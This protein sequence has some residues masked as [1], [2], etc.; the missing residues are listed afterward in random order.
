M[1]NR[2]RSPSRLTPAVSPT[3]TRPTPALP[4]SG[5]IEAMKQPWWWASVIAATLVTVLVIGGLAF[6]FRPAAPRPAEGGPPPLAAPIPETSL[7]YLLP[8]SPAMLVSLGGFEGRY[9][10]S[11]HAYQLFE[12]GMAYWWE[13][14]A[15][16][17]DPI[18]IIDGA[19]TD[20]TGANWSQFKNTWTA[21]PARSSGLLPGSHRPQRADDGFWAVVVLQRRRAGNAGAGPGPGRRG[22]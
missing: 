17:M 16:P 7:V 8:D 18:Y 15:T 21:E 13:N 22:Q 12:G 4:A 5:P 20:N 2:P 6:W 19:T 11:N 3:E 9:A 14:P 1:R 10:R